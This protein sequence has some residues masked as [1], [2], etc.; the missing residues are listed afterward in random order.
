MMAKSLIRKFLCF[1][2][3]SL[4]MEFLG[5]FGITQN[6][7]NRIKKCLNSHPLMRKLFQMMRCS[8]YTPYS[9]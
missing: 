7:D 4:R 9:L 6:H 1:R 8:L 3:S 2:I 5:T